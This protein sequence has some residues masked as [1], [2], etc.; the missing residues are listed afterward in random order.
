MSHAKCSGSLC[1]APGCGKP[2]TPLGGHLCPFGCMA[3]YCSPDC[4]LGDMPRHATASSAS[5]SGVWR[6]LKECR[7]PGV[8]THRSESP[9]LA[10]CLGC[11][12]VASDHKRCGACLTAMFCGG[13]CLKA[14]WP[15]HK[16]ECS[17]V[18]AW[19]TSPS[20]LSP[21]TLGGVGDARMQPWIP[22]KWEPLQRLVLLTLTGLERVDP[23]KQYLHI[24]LCPLPAGAPGS[25]SFGLVSALVELAEVVQ[26]PTL[27]AELGRA[28][29][30]DD[31]FRV[32]VEL[33]A[34]ISSDAKSWAH[35][36]ALRKAEMKKHVAGSLDC[37]NARMREL[38]EGIMKE[39]EAPVS[40]E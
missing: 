39:L 37:S 3:T 24:R 15:A 23:A 25:V 31:K 28:L 26:C 8:R 34:L 32:V 27:K 29:A 14:A 22:S 19:R 17:A 11:G 5:A 10:S 13:A 36:Y 16:A 33:K 1:P 30:G 21:L 20:R 38:L 7:S 18:K 12:A 6:P 2:T 35:V 40:V 9:A 4:I